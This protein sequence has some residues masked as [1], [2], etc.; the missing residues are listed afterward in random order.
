LSRLWSSTMV[1]SKLARSCINSSIRLVDSS[2]FTAVFWF[3]SC[4]LSGV[5]HRRLQHIVIS[6][7]DRSYQSK[8][9]D[10]LDHLAQAAQIVSWEMHLLACINVLSFWVWQHGCFV[11][12]I[13]TFQSWRLWVP[14]EGQV[15]NRATIA[16]EGSGIIYLQRRLVRQRRPRLAHC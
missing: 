1:C 8:R 10:R 4:A 11:R 2:S 7:L 15:F 5:R 14:C 16:A 12:S 9:V 6:N 3:I 13:R